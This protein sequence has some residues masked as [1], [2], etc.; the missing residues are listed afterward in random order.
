M[1]LRQRLVRR[2]VPGV[3]GAVVACLCAVSLA[4]PAAADSQRTVIGLQLMT[5]DG[6]G[7]QPWS[8]F[9]S[10]NGQL[11]RLGTNTY[12]S[13]CR[14]TTDSA[15]H[16]EPWGGRACKGW[17]ISTIVGEVQPDG[18]PP[19][20]GASIY[21]ESN[22]CYLDDYGGGSNCTPIYNK[23]V[24]AWGTRLA[25]SDG[26][27]GPFVPSAEVPPPAPTTPAHA[28]WQTHEQ[29]V[30]VL[31]RRALGREPDAGGRSSWIARL[32]GAAYGQGRREAAAQVVSGFF[33]SDEYRLGTA[34]T[35]RRCTTCTRQSCTAPPRRR[36]PRAGLSGSPNPARPVTPWSGGSRS[37]QN[38]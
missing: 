16:S 3:V 25:Y 5:D 36:K 19:H 17:D 15:G 6:S 38:L 35:R 21:T 26:T 22:L 7:P 20:S 12:K 28:C 1:S 37:Q 10:H 27:K 2:A 14:T 29:F 9:Y 23:S 34:R 18:S 30:D 4:Q 31:Y 13:D 24:S 33:G 8:T 11:P 32:D